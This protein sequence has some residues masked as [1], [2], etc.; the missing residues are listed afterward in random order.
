MGW[1]SHLAA[2]A[3]AGA[4]ASSM[5]A[6]ASGDTARGD[7]AP[8]EPPRSGPVAVD[9]VTLITGDKVVLQRYA[10]GRQA[11]TVDAAR[12]REHIAFRSVQTDGKLRVIPSDAAGHLAA[13]RS[14]GR[15]RS[16]RRRGR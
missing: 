4:L 6:P 1:T 5:I 3:A 10:D 11:A 2:I 7:T 9:T 16:L 8:G 12:G 14:P 15:R 13:V